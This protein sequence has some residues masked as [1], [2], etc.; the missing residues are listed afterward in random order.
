MNSKDKIIDYFNSLPEVKRIHELEPYID[1]NL[2]IKLQFEDLKQKQRIMVLKKEKNLDFQKEL[3]DYNLA[4]EKLLD[5]PFVEEYLELIDYVK[6]LLD[7][8][9]NGI[10]DNL[11]KAI[12]E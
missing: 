4:K 11:Y 8:L 9:T 7:S 10:E 3:N 12:N 6:F 1:K 2:D 5:M